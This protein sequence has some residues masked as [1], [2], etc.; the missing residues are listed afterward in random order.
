MSKEK[1]MNENLRQQMTENYS[2]GYSRKLR[3][4]FSLKN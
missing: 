4:S 2:H 1:I 3:H